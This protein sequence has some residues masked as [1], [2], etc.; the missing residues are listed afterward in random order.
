MSGRFVRA[1]KFRHV[2]GQ[3]VKKELCYDN[4]RLTKNA[5][6]SNLIKVNGKYLSVNWDSSGGG[7]FA[8]VPLHEMGKLP[9]QVPLFRGHTAAVL[10]T[11][12]NPFDDDVVASASDDGKVGIWK[13]PAGFSMKK[14]L[15]EGEEIQDIAPRKMLSGHSKK[16]GHV[17][18]HPV[19]NNILASSSGD[20]TIKIWNVET[21]KCL[22]TLQHDDLITSF[23]FNYD[24][25]R[26]ASTS[27]NKKLRVWDI[28]NEKIITEGQG[29]TGAKSSRVVWLGN[30][31]RFV[32]T[33]F[34][35]LSD[36]Q[37]ALWDC[38]DVAKGP[39]N[40]F[41]FLDSSAGIC[42]PFYDEGTHCLYLGGKGDGNIRYF[43]YTPEKDEFFALSEYQS[44]EPQR[45]LAFMPKRAL[46][47]KDHEVVRFYKTVNDS[48]VEPIQFFV[49]RRADTFQ[50]DIY[51]LAR[52]AE[53]SLSA[54]EWTDGK[55][56][57]PKVIDLQEV[58]DGKEARAVV[59][60]REPEKER[61]AE[62]IAEEAEQQKKELEK[63]K[64]EREAKEREIEEQKKKEEEEGKVSS[65]SVPAKTEEM[66]ESKGVQEFLSKSADAEEAE[67][68]DENEEWTEVKNEKPS[69]EKEQSKEPEPE[70]EAE[71]EVAETESET[72]DSGI[73]APEPSKVELEGDASIVR[74]IQVDNVEDT[75]VRLTQ[76]VAALT[77]KVDKLVEQMEAKDQRIS[78][79]EKLIAK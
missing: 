53:P 39:I 33:G 73:L 77:V 72:S 70:V 41:Q 16:V 13:V 69:A 71:A 75:I 10:D 43:E 58:F 68:E 9:D 50:S 46:S 5:W 61:R 1:S 48:M 27:R 8:V 74:K 44:V 3:P 28:R 62:K 79:L 40:G 67:S 29:H 14:T 63:Q 4:V 30:T 52:A 42:M 36:R 32:T 12:W 37:F 56:A 34:S 24:G 65:S 64:L 15:D 19:A 49:P 18:W 57:A 7:A 45:G 20:Y 6:D 25:S 26:I 31:E 38:N 17:L 2:F 66:F 22:F 59:D 60:D 55:N 35:R 78:E 21:E 54:E 11:D 23:A 47:I 76:H 51:P